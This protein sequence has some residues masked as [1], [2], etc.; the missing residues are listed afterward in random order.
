MFV[1][2]YLF[3]ALLV[4]HSFAYAQSMYIKAPYSIQTHSEQQSKNAKMVASVLVVSVYLYVSFVSLAVS[5][6]ARTCCYDIHEPKYIY[7]VRGQIVFVCVC[8]YTTVHSCDGKGCVYNDG[9]CSPYTRHTAIATTRYSHCCR[10]RLFA[11]TA[12]P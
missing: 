6:H 3:L 2:L 4:V 10:R 8:Y 1:Q 9:R 7:C 5:V 12:A 11:S